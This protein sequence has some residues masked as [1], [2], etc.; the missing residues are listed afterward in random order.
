MNDIKISEE[1]HKSLIRYLDTYF[2]ERNLKETLKLFSTEISGFGTGLDEKATNLKDFEKLYLRDISQ[3][4]NKIHYKI[5][6]LDIKVPS[7]YAGFLSCILDI[8]TNV[9]EQDISLNCLRLSIFFFKRQE[10][11]LIEHMHISLPTVE[12]G[13]DEA[14]PIKELEDRNKVLNRLVNEKT[15]VLQDTNEKLKIALDEIKVL[16]GILLIC[17][18]CKKIQA[19]DESW[20]LLESYIK[21]HSEAEFSHGICP[22]CLKKHYPDIEI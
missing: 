14:Y 3:A 10:E 4:P 11:W 8:K 6:H 18:H 5:Q 12:H 15:K 19:N 1:I 20:H 17:S 22:D 13:K 21:E 7:K 2:G 16:R 9:L